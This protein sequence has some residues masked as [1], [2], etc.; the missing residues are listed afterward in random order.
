MHETKRT[1][2][3]LVPAGPN[4]NPVIAK[5]F[6]ARPLLTPSRNRGLRHRRSKYYH[7]SSTSSFAR[8]AGIYTYLIFFYIRK[9]C[10]E[11]PE[12][13]YAFCLKAKIEY[14][15]DTPPALEET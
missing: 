12:G 7:I 14:D 3:M 4:M 11:S 13:M 8:T 10:S 2:E 6:M 9:N 5:W 1:C 15:F